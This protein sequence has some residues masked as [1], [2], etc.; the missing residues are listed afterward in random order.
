MTIRD[1]VIRF[2][3]FMVILF[4]VKRCINGFS[5]CFADALHLGNFVNAGLLYTLYTAEIA[6]QFPPTF[7][8]NALD[9]FQRG[10][11]TL[12]ISSCPMASNGKPVRFIPYVLN[13]VPRWRIGR[14]PEHIAGH[15][16]NQLFHPRSARY[17]LRHTDQR[18]V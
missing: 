11:S 7:R 13:Q 16:V 6:Y 17:A 9:T 8:A 10:L 12:F 4:V 18:Y 14:D 3:K 2:G 15:G 5:Q 1:M